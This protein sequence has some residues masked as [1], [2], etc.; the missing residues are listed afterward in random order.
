MQGAKLPRIT[1]INVRVYKAALIELLSE[2][3]EPYVFGVGDGVGVWLWAED[4]G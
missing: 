3:L 1:P 4:P 2:A